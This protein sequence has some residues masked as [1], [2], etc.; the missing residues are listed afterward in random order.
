MKSNRI[1]SWAFDDVFGVERLPERWIYHDPSRIEPMKSGW[2]G[3][4][5]H[6]HTEETKRKIS[7]SQIGL[8]GAKSRRGLP[9]TIDG[10]TYPT[11]R[12]AAKALGVTPSTIINWKRN[13]K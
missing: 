6:K 4:H 11:Q 7:E 2:G 13:G 10:V 3:P 12:E 1:D 8:T 5:V 9:I